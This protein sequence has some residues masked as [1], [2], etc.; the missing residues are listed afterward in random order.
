MAIVSAG[1]LPRLAGLVVG[2]PTLRLRGDYLAIATLGFAEIIRIVFLNIDY[3]GG[4][5]GMQVSHL[6]TGRMLYL[7]I[8][9]DLCYCELYK[10]QTWTSMYLHS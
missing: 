8:Y 9:Y 3:V 10:F 5:A 2:I 6:T 1:L 7:P 4:A